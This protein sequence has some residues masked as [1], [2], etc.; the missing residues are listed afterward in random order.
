[1]SVEIHDPAFASVVGDGVE[2]ECL[3]SRFEFTE[4]PI[5]HPKEKHLTFS[6]I[7]GGCCHVV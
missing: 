5:W 4:G 2:V 7:H 6:D 3:S 1:M